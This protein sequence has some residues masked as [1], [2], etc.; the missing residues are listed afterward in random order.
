MS[1]GVNRTVFFS[2][3]ARRTSRAS[4]TPSNPPR[5]VPFSGRS[6]VFEISADTVTWATSSDGRSK[7]VSTCGSRTA[8]GPL[9]VR[10][11]SLHRPMSLSGGMGFQSTQLT[12]RSVGVGAKTSTATALRAP[13]RAR[14]VT[15]SS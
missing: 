9:S 11:T 5:S 4:R 12:A 10:E 1:A 2:R 7:V 15:S 13:G 6:V 14:P 3:G 8:M